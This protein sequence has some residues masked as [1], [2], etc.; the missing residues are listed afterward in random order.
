LASDV[1]R[2]RR[3]VILWRDDDDFVVLFSPEDIVVFR[4]NEPEPLHDARRG[5]VRLPRRVEQ[6]RRQVAIVRAIMKL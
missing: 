5:A 1:E 6:A 2:P 4:H 3:L